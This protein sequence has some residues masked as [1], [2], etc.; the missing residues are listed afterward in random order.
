[1]LPNEAYLLLLLLPYRTGVLLPRNRCP[2]RIS[3]S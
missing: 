3:Y 2:G 1:M